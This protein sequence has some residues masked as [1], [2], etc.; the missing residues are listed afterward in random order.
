M[1]GKLCRLAKQCG[2]KLACDH[3]HYNRRSRL[4]D[5]KTQDEGFTEVYI[6]R[7]RRVGNVD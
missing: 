7:R 5:S 2:L 4:N 1:L 3:L 6:N